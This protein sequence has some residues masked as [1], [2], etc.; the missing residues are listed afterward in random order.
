MIIFCVFPLKHGC[1]NMHD[2]IWF[3]SDFFRHFFYRF[4]LYCLSVRLIDELTS[5]KNARNQWYYLVI[6]FEMLETLKFHFISTRFSLTP[7]F[8]IKEA[9]TTE[10]QSAKFGFIKC[11]HLVLCDRQIPKIHVSPAVVM[12]TIHLKILDNFPIRIVPTRSQ[13]FYAVPFSSRLAD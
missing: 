8:V 12:A 4:A 13:H 2:Y 3:G 9:W 5:T 1:V 10:K 6:K 11:V 7:H